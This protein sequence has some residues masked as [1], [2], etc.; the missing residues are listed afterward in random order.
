MSTCKQ[1]INS[2]WDV[3]VRSRY[4]HGD[5]KCLAPIPQWLDWSGSPIVDFDTDATRCDAFE[6]I[7]RNEK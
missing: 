1:C 2:H 4:G 7:E 5:G 3:R 6:Q